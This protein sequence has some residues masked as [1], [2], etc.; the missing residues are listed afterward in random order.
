MVIL[1]VIPSVADQ[2]AAVLLQ[3]SITDRLVSSPELSHSGVK[4]VSAET[5]P[6]GRLIC[7]GSMPQHLEQLLRQ[8]R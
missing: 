6:V 1:H 3:D 4:Q 2:G 8:G 5:V 7:G